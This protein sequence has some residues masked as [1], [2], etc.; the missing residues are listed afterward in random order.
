MEVV[1]VFSD[2]ENQFVPVPKDF[3][4]KSSEVLIKP[5]GDVL[6]LIPRQRD[7]AGM[8]ETLGLFTD[9]FFSEGRQ[10]LPPQKRDIS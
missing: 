9:D 5:V 2:G 7:M 8:M 6:I 3:K 10:D 4:F 1:K